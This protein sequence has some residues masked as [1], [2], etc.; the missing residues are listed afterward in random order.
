MNLNLLLT[1]SSTELANLTD[2]EILEYAEKNGWLKACRVDDETRR[3]RQSSIVS[4]DK[5]LSAKKQKV[6]AMFEKMFG[7]KLDL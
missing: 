4:F 1:G 7:E 6:A 5:T 2:K 3:Q